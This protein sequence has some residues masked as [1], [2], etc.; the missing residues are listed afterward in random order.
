MIT[1]MRYIP[2]KLRSR[3]AQIA[4]HLLKL[5][6]IEPHGFEEALDQKRE[7]LPVDDWLICD[8]IDVYN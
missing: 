2:E 3:I 6:Y 5:D 1:K 4:P 7:L 8:P